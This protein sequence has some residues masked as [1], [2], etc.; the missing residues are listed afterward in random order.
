RA[1]CGHRARRATDRRGPGRD[2]GCRLTHEGADDGVQV[3]R[4]GGRALAKGEWIGTAAARARRCSFR[5]WRA[6]ESN[7]DP[8]WR[9]EGERRLTQAAIHN[10]WRIAEVFP[11]GVRDSEVRRLLKGELY[12]YQCEG[13]LF[14]ARAGR[15]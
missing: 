3:A 7:E 5:R 2:Q 10:I 12:E 6:R 13:A 15:C 1:H 11:R 4:D 14:A 8:C 9:G